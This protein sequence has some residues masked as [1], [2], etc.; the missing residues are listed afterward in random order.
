MATEGATRIALDG[1]LPLNTYGGQLSA[2]R[3][4]GY[5]LLHEACLQLRGE[6]GER[7]VSQRPE[8]GVVS[9]GGGPV[10]GCMLLTC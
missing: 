3:M 10:A 2:G 6:A 9:V 4:H 7:Q 1:A 8:V 5:W